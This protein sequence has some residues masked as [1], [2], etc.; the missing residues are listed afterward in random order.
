MSSYI[1][2]Q[3][4]HMFKQV[5]ATSLVALA[6]GSSSVFAAESRSD[7]RITAVIPSTTFYAQPVNKPEFGTAE[8][9]SYNIITKKLSSLVQPFELKASTGSV[10]AFIEGN[11]YLFNGASA[12]NI[13]L[14]VKLGST[15]LTGTS[16]EV[17]ATG[18]A[19]TGVS[20][21]LDISAGVIPAGATGSYSADFTIVFE[22]SA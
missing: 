10:K 11:S 4:T 19:T 2:K 5:V 13:P 16:S 3:V 8:V 7:I 18:T 9:M 21:L 15:T 6:I 1:S 12:Q 14:I 20:Q 22:P 17:A